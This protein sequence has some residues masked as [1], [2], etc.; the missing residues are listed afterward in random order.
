VIY[1]AARST[2]SRW[3]TSTTSAP[4]CAPLFEF[5]LKHVPAPQVDRDKPLQLQVAPLDYSPYMGRIAIGRIKRG[6]IRPNQERG[7]RHVR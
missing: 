7:G 5:I 6:R 4:T 2:A 1:A 3:R